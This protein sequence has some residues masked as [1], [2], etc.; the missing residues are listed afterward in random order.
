MCYRVQEDHQD[1]FW[2]CQIHIYASSFFIF[3]NI[4]PTPLTFQKFFTLFDTN[5]NQYIFYALSLPLLQE[6]VNLNSWHNVYLYI[7]ISSGL[8][9]RFGVERPT[10][11]NWGWKIPL[12]G[13]VLDVRLFRAIIFGWKS[14]CASTSRIGFKHQ[15]FDTF[16]KT[17]LLKCKPSL[18]LILFRGI[19][20]IL[21]A[22]IRIK[23]I[24]SFC[25]KQGQIVI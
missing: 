8:L 15:P 19:F 1:H 7:E 22:S 9:K 18:E 14:T 5:W 4:F 23:F 10:Y 2:P 11:L 24:T 16:F 6:I 20:R 17:R 21:K 12:N 25:Y 3:K 13:I